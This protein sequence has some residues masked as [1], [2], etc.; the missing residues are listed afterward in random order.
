MRAQRSSSSQLSDQWLPT[1]QAARA[2]GCSTHTL[3]RYA[4]RDEFLVE[5]THWRRGPYVNSPLVWNIPKCLEA[6]SRQGRCR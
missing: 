2:V 1:G 3:K 4:Y 6:I 5:G